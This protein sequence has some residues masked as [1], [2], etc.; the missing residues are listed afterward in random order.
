MTVDISASGRPGSIPFV[1]GRPVALMVRFVVMKHGMV[2]FN[3]KDN[4]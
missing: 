2:S 4:I 3:I 1:S